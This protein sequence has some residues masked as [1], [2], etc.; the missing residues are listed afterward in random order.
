MVA[1]HCTNWSSRVGGLD[2]AEI[3]Q[4]K[5]IGSGNKIADETIDPYLSDVDH[6]DCPYSFKCRYSDAAFADMDG[7][8]DIDL[9]NI[10]K[11]ESVNSR[12]V[13][14]AGTVYEINK[15]ADGSS[16]R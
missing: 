15:R 11:P 3:F 14:P 9:G 6:E 2:D 16:W 1:S 13:S 4:P 10:A 12:S 5:V 8:V 7:E